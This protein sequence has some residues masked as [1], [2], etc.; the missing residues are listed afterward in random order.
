MI[1]LCAYNTDDPH[2]RPVLE[3]SLPVTLISNTVGGSVSTD[4]GRY[5]CNDLYFKSLK[6]R[7]L[8]QSIF[9]HV[10]PYSVM[11]QEQQRVHI[12]RLVSLISSL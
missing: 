8:W 7:H 5:F 9:V 11:P 10:P 4:P 1:E 6:K 2:A 3:T 12:S